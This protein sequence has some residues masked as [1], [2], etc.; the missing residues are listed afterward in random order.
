MISCIAN[1]LASLKR[2]E[3]ARD[4]NKKMIE[5][6]YGHITPVKHA[7]RILKGLPGW[8]HIADA[9]SS[10]SD[11]PQNLDCDPLLEL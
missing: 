5:N 11:A 3:K 2:V 1:G 7:D 6:H 9:A 10:Q 4:F 8:G